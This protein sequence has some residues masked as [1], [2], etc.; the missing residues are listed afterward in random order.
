MMKGVS[1]PAGLMASSSGDFKAHNIAPATN[2]S[3]G[4]LTNLWQESPDFQNMIVRRL[5]MADVGKL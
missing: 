1:K 5:S 4:D 3:I 2:L